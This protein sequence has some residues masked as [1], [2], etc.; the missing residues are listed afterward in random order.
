MLDGFEFHWPRGQA[1]YL[2]DPQNARIELIVD[3]FVPYISSNGRRVRSTK[4]GPLT[5]A[6]PLGRHSLS[7]ATSELREA[8]TDPAARSS[9]QVEPP[10]VTS[11]SSPDEPESG[12]DVVEHG[13][14]TRGPR[15]P[16]WEPVKAKI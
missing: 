3:N 9:G 4:T 10:A 14:E 15:I 11:G 13:R 5:T 1:P 7:E 6:A 8:E 16:E 2:L 12:E